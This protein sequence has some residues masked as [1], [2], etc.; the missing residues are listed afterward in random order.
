MTPQPEA[1]RVSSMR[2]SRNADALDERGPGSLELVRFESAIQQ[3]DHPGAAIVDSIGPIAVRGV[4]REEKLLRLQVL[5]H[6]AESLI[7]NVI[8]IE[9][10][11]G[12]RLDARVTAACSGDIARWGEA[13]AT[14]FVF[15]DF[16]ASAQEVAQ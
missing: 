2:I 8:I 4:G 1:G 15:T 3:N 9:R 7:L 14:A 12:E 6:A 5:E 13:A 16:W 11:R 10:D